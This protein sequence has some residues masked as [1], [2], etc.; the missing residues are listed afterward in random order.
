PRSP[1][2]RRDASGS[3]PGSRCSGHLRRLTWPSEAPKQ[4]S[5]RM[6]ARRTL[7]CVVVSTSLLLLV[8]APSPGAS[9]ARSSGTTRFVSGRVPVL[10]AS[11]ELGATRPAG[12][13]GHPAP[14][15]L[16]PDANPWHLAGTIPGAVIHDISFPTLK[17]GYAAAELGQVWKT[18]DG[19]R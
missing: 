12:L 4:R 6:T 5:I 10:G 2:A 14:A 13:M 3:G 11:R 17:V 8:A 9:A 1:T 15:R 16:A 7:W 18:T 19:G